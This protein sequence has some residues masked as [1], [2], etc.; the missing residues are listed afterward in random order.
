MLSLARESIP[1]VVVLAVSILIVPIAGVRI[2]NNGGF[3]LQQAA[4]IHRAGG[5][6]SSA[7]GDFTAR[8]PLY[9]IMLAIGFNVAGKSVYTAIILTRMCFAATILA[10]Y[11]M[12][13]WFYSGT[14]GFLFAI[15]VASSY[16]M[17]RIACY[18]D[19]DIVL[20]LFI[21]LFTM[22]CGQSFVRK[23]RIWPILSGFF[24]TASLLV[25]ETAL[26]AVPLPFL[27]TIFSKPG[28]RREALKT[29]AWMMSIAIVF[30]SPWLVI[31][32]QKY[33]SIFAAFGVAHPQFISAE[34]V[35]AGFNSAASYWLH[36][37]SAGLQKALLNYYHMLEIMTPAAPL[38]LTAWLIVFFRAVVL[39]KTVDLVL[40]MAA[41]S[42]VPLA[43]LTGHLNLRVGQTTMLY[44]LLNCCLAVSI[45]VVSDVAA[46][47]VKR[48]M[49]SF[50]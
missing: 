13:R 24:L 23:G 9:P 18:I 48:L 33:G 38:L 26:L 42:F 32:A 46:Q 29:T 6:S 17:N 1:V 40:A 3:Y 19:T 28:E 25:K 8:G 34:A 22:S 21:L 50:G 44:L 10:A 2:S 15:F 35:G 12:G 16:G 27:V 45:T 11:I 41:A 20:P 5:L 14:V 39:R 30:F 47:L 7:F 43:V 31:A 37:I 4:E 49:H 36:A